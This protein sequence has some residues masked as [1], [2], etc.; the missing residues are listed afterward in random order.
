M[1][2]LDLASKRVTDLSALDN[3]M[4]RMNEVIQP[5]VR[6]IERF[7][8]MMQPIYDAIEQYRPRIVEFGKKAA[9]AVRP[10]I[11]IEKMGDSQYVY[12]DYMDKA[13]IN[14]L[15]ISDNVNKTLRAYMVRDHYKKVDVTIE[16]SRLC[17]LMKN[18]SRIYD[19]SVMAFRG[20]NN[21]LA[22]LG[23]TAVFDGLL[24]DISKKNTPSLKPR[25]DVI[26]AKLEKDEV[27]DQNEYAMLT[28]AITFEKTI[29]TFSANSE[30]SKKEPK[31][32]NRHW[33][34]HGRSLRRKTKLDVVKMINL[35]YGM[36][37]INELDGHM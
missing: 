16:K 22:V 12:W 2:N 36:L 13:F 25:I 35:I 34:A 9:E 8:Q 19:Q 30:F 37:L 6:A 28:L 17:P 11:A 21:D 32:L 15:V 33:I 26:K 27:L 7:H 14:D 31:G 3:S 1:N 23:F 10:L 24:S 5:I 18:H 29:D 20:G 4:H